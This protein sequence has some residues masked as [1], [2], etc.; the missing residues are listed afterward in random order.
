MDCVSFEAF[1][2]QA[3]HIIQFLV[4]VVVIS[5]ISEINNDRHTNVSSEIKRGI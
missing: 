1:H 5:M 3:Q 2:N 4:V